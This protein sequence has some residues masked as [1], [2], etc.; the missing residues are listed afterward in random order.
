MSYL[1]SEAYLQRP[2]IYRPEL[3][4]VTGSTNSAILFSQ[5]L[6]WWIKMEKKE[7]YKYKTPPK[8]SENETEEEFKKRTKTYKKGDSWC[9]ELYL[10]KREFDEALKK[11]AHYGQR[12]TGETEERKNRRFYLY[13]KLIDNYD[14]KEEETEEEWHERINKHLSQYLRCCIV[15]RTDKNR[16]ITYYNIINIEFLNKFLGDQVW[17]DCALEK[18]DKIFGEIKETNPE[19][20]KSNFRKNGRNNQNNT[21]EVT[22]S[23]FRITQNKQKAEV[24]KCNFRGGSEVTNCYLPYSVDYYYIDYCIY[25]SNIYW[26]FSG[27]I[28]HLP[29][30]FDQEKNLPENLIYNLPEISHPISKHSS[31]ININQNIESILEKNLT[32]KDDVSMESDVSHP[33]HNETPLEHPSDA[34]K[35]S[36]DFMNKIG[37][38]PNPSHNNSKKN[39]STSDPVSLRSQHHSLTKTNHP[40]SSHDSAS[41]RSPNHSLH[42]LPTSC[43]GHAAQSVSPPTQ[44]VPGTFIPTRRLSS[45]PNKRP[46]LIIH[47]NKPKDKIDLLID[48]WNSL[49]NVTK[50]K[51]RDT[52]IYKRIRIKLRRLLIGSFPRFYHI[53]D[54]NN[55]ID[56]SFLTRPLTE[57]EIKQ[58]FDNLSRFCIDGYSVNHFKCKPKSKSLDTFLF[59]SNRNSSI[60]FLVLSNPP[61]LNK[62]EKMDLNNLPF[63]SHYLDMFNKLLNYDDRDSDK[64]QQKLAFGIKELVDFHSRNQHFFNHDR[65]YNLSYFLELYKSF[66][67]LNFSFVK[68]AIVGKKTWVWDR[69]C[70]FASDQC[71]EYIDDLE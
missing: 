7:F 17:S 65:L 52:D 23:N 45:R 38:Q 32:I 27:Q 66:L 12:K 49:G 22:K 30:K 58:G 19:V 11:I 59:N 42:I 39:L 36:N 48:Y 60:F 54:D 14:R 33:H 8:R 20:T 2:V 18:I 25:Y 31:D 15:Y 29:K 61:Y 37:F 68:P 70:N 21:P 64:Q 53:C 35:R 24:T 6:Y 4:R 41:L 69:F 16:N 26:N 57:E 40:T 9:R 71:H 56:N 5:I 44:G 1:N 63:K 47:T 34:W 28:E 51:K 10:T 3:K 13:Q 62:D 43:Q 46:A 67:S 55:H 50:H